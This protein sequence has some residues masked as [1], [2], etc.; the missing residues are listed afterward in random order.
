MKRGPYKIKN[1]KQARVVRPDGTVS[2]RPLVR[3]SVTGEAVGS[4]IESEADRRANRPRLS[5]HPLVTGNGR[6]RLH[7]PLGLG[8]GKVPARH[9]S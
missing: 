4:L 8:V 3:D 2:Y 5:D 9:G 1:R 6:A 7:R